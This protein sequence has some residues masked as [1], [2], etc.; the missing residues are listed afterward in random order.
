MTREQLLKI[1]KLY[2]IEFK[3]VVFIMDMLRKGQI[4]TSSTN[5]Q[6]Y[7]KLIEKLDECRGVT[8]DYEQRLEE[9]KNL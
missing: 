2:S 8:Q 4:S 3:C 7:D 9:L 6:V 5:E 1:Q